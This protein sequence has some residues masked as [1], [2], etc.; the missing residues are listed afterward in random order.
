MSEMDLRQFL[1]E[2]VGAGDLTTDALIPNVNGKASVIC[3][4]DAVMAGSEEAAEIFGLLGVSSTLLAA[5]GQRVR[6]GTEVMIIEGPLRGI[7]TGERT[8]LNFLMKMSGIATETRSLVRMIREKDENIKIA[9]TRKTTPGFRAFEKKAIALGGGWPHREGLYDM[10]LIKDNH[11]AACGGVKEAMERIRS[12]PKDVVVEIEVSNIDD[13]VIAANMGAHIIMADHMSPS[14][15]KTLMN[16][17]KKIDRNIQVEASGNITAEN[18]MDYACCADIISVGAL[19]H[20]S[21]A[22]HFSLDIKE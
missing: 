10:V 19:T 11:V 14:E 8:A 13:A 18:I 4:E 5:D 7:L 9:G 15:T 3:E 17:V 1:D 20:S 2:D 16:A 6:K 22:V 12:I 21:K